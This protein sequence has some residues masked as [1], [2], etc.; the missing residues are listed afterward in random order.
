M[1][2]KEIVKGAQKEHTTKLGDLLDYHETGMS[3]FQHDYL[4]T[5]RAGLTLYGMFKQSLRETYKRV[6]GVRELSCDLEKLQVEIEEQ[7]FIMNN[8]EN[9]FKRKYAA[10]EYKRKVMTVEESDRNYKDTIRTLNDFYSQAVYLKEKLGDL[11]AE[12]IESLDKEMWE[13]KF[14]EMAAID[15]ISTGRLS[16]GSYEVL[17]SL[18]SDMKLKAA[19]KLQDPDS[20]ILEYE[21]KEDIIIPLE[22]PRLQLD[23]P[24]F[25]ELSA[26]IDIEEKNLS[27]E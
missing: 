10:I 20:L 25:K 15:L 2:E 12:R 17:H 11:D 7:E 22:L 4:V 13:A 18:P 19:E 26:G 16:A 9:E 1:D 3:K 5:K 23:I 27:L 8:D 21:N 24:N 14:N 6:R